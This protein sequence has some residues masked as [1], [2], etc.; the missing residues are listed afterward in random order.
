MKML[1]DKLSGIETRYDEVNQKLLT[2][3]DDYQLAADLGKEKA[4]LDPFIESIQRYKN[5]LEQLEG[6]KSLAETGDQE[7]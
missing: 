4:E 3:G 1:L 7:A 2:V 5:S 6:A